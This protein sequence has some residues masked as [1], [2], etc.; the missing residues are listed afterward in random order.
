M[1]ECVINEVPFAFSETAGGS[2]MGTLAGVNGQVFV[3]G[4]SGTA[5]NRTIDVLDERGAIT[6]RLLVGLPSFLGALAA[7]QTEAVSH[8]VSVYGE[9]VIADL[10]FERLPDTGSISG[11][12]FV[13]ANGNGVFD[14]GEPSLAGAI[15]FVDTNAND[16]P[17]ADEIQT[18]TDVDGSYTL[19][20]IPVGEVLV[21][22]LP[23]W[24]PVCHTSSIQ[25]AILNFLTPIF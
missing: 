10:D 8:R 13:D 7:E 15:V 20:D 25:S 2:T 4:G 6:H 9:D 11:I 24:S 16:W 18:V 22:S 3:Q 17:D 19:S 5:S 21:R 23:Q 1:C 14:D 12:Q